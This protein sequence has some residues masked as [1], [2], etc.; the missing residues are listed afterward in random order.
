MPLFL[1]EITFNIT[2]TEDV[3]R[4]HAM[5]APF[6]KSAD[7]FPKG[8]TVKAGPW[9]SNEEAKIYWILDMPDHSTTVIP[10]WNHLA[11]GLITGR[12]MTPIVE[13]PA[14]DE[15]VKNLKEV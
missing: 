3:K 6:S 2:S 14:M 7:K 9:V 1:D 11:T 5:V 12:R 13:W 10:W 4:F 8:V 15:L